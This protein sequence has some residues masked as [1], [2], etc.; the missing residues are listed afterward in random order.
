MDNTLSVVEARPI[1]LDFKPVLRKLNDAD[2]F[3][4]CQANSDWRIECTSAGEV[5]IMPPTGGMTGGRNFHLTG[6]FHA[7]VQANG[8]GKGFDSSTGFTLPNGAKRSPDLAWLSLARWQ[9]LTAAERE[10]FPPLCPDFVVELRSRTD[11]LSSLQ[12]KMQE[13][14]DNGAQLGWLIDPI[15]Q[16]VYI[17]APQTPV[18]C[19]DKPSQVS[20][21]PLLP[22]FVLEMCDIW[23]LR[24]DCLTPVR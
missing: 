8:T 15:E 3:E 13:Y 7:W 9:T 11:Q 12:D 14:M 20:G 24:D 22:G 23:E 21:A 17:Y 6:I 19:L 5:I 18:V 1:V 2:F 4:F 10:Q 16:K